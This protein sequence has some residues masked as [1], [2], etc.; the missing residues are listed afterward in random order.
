MRLRLG[1]KSIERDAARL[2][3]L[4]GPPSAGGAATT[5]FFVE[6]NTFQDAT[7]YYLEGAGVALPNGS[8]K[9]GGGEFMIPDYF[10]GNSI[11]VE[12]IAEPGSS[13]NS[14]K[15]YGDLESSYAAIGDAITLDGVFIQSDPLVSNTHQIIASYTF[16][17]TVALDIHKFV[18]SRLGGHANDTFNQTIYLVGF[19]ITLL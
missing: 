18:Y 11:L 9:D 1:D 14:G 16:T 6:A 13:G 10:T 15:V 2:R 19:R 7:N 4:L 8:T 12:A 17:P 3:A 5:I